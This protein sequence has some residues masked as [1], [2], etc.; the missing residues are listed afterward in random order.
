MFRPPFELI[1]EIGKYEQHHRLSM[2]DEKS[3]EFRRFILEN[4][5]IIE[6]I[7]NEDAK[8][9]K[10]ASKKE[11]LD[12]K[13]EKAKTKAKEAN[14]TIIS[15]ISDDNV[16]Q[17]FITG[18][19]EFIHFFEAVI[20]AVPMSPETREAVN[21]FGETRDTTIRNI[22]AVGAKDKM[23]SININEIKKEPSK[24]SA[25][26]KKAE[27]IKINTVKKKKTA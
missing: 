17:H 22:V 27:S 8:E 26:K 7:L 4:R 20:D 24:S 23:E 15:I 19:L 16:Q 6:A 9:K 21:K 5:E 14:E 11:K 1:N 12:D 10:K 2:A 3:E 13:K 25:G 18:C